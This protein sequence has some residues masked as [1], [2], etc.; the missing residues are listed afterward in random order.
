MHFALIDK[1]KASKLVC[2]LLIY[3]P[4]CLGQEQQSDLY[5]LQVKLPRYMLLSV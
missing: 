4:S 5:N 3:L 2:S 1:R